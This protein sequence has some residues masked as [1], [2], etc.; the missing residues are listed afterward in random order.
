MCRA[1]QNKGLLLEIVMSVLRR[2]GLGWCHINVGKRDDVGLR[3]KAC[4]INGCANVW[5]VIVRVS[6]S[7]F[8]KAR[9]PLMSRISSQ[10]P[11]T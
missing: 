1:L 2:D 4:G 9:S 6:A 3:R 8:G 5:G 11:I 7:L 10:E